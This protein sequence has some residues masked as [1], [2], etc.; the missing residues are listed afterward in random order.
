M[1]PFSSRLR[2]VL[3]AAVAVSGATAAGTAH[4]AAGVER[5]SVSCYAIYS[6]SGG[7]LLGVRVVTP[8]FP[9]W[10]DVVPAPMPV[11]RADGVAVFTPNGRVSA[12]CHDDPQI[13]LV[14]GSPFAGTSTFHGPALAAREQAPW[15]FIYRHYVG[16][17]T[18]VVKQSDV[19]IS[20]QLQLDFSNWP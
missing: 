18:V 13:W 8:D 20:A 1:K 16:R 3:L 4:S 17:G 10:I 12:V 19:R 5:V 14:D 9:P 11:V 2:L 6:S 15:S 7:S